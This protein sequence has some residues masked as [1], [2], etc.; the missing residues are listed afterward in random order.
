VIIAARFYHQESTFVPTGFFLD[1]K[2]LDRVR[3]VMK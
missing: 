1:P 3:A 2:D